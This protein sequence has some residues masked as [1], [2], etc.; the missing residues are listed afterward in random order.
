MAIDN[1]CDNII[2]ET[3]FLNQLKHI[4]IKQRTSEYV[5][6]FENSENFGEKIKNFKYLSNSLI[7]SAEFNYKTNSITV[8]L[9][10]PKFEK[11]CSITKESPTEPDKLPIIFDKKSNIL[12]ISSE[13]VSFLWHFRIDGDNQLVFQKEL[14]KET[15]QAEW[16][17]FDEIR[18]VKNFKNE[19]N[20][21][22]CEC[23]GIGRKDLYK[24][25]FNKCLKL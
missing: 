6:L 13:D 1:S 15:H 9:S 12:T 16:V 7:A 18:H 25:T 20:K 22:V 5:D 11:L 8:S 21:E 10:S 2:I 14:L 17:S 24:I 19:E 23:L 3:C 4:N